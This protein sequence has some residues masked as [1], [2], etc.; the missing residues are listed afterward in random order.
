MTAFHYGFHLFIPQLFTMP[1]TVLSNRNT[2]RKTDMAP[3]LVNCKGEQRRE[4]VVN[5]AEIYVNFSVTHATQRRFI[6]LEE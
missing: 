3:A 4:R 6:V 1:G 5:V 2:V